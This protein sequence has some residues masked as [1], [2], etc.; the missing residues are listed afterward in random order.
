MKIFNLAARNVFRHTRRSIITAI[1]ISVGLSAMIFMDS[2]MNSVDK[3]AEEN[4]LHYELGNITVFAQGYYREEGRYGLDFIID[5]PENLLNKLSVI[6][7]V[8]AGT[9][10]I[11]FLCQ[12]NNGTDELPIL[13]IG[14]EPQQDEKVFKL[15]QA[16]VKGS[17]L[18]NPDDILIGEALAKDL[19]L[20]IG[21]IAT[22]IAKDRDGTYNAYDF[23]VV[24]LINSGHPAIDRNS[25]II[26]LHRAQELLNLPNA[27]TEISVKTNAKNLAGLKSEI[28][29]QIGNKY[30]LYTWRELYT[31]ILEISGMKRSVQF[32]LALVVVIIAAVG[33]INT[34]LMAVM[35][36]VNEIGMLKAMGFSNSHIVKMFIYEGGIIGFFGSLIGC[37]LGIALS[38]YLKYVGIDLSQQFENIDI[39][40]PIKF[41][42]KGE[43]NYWTV[44]AVLGFGVIISILVTL[45]P[46]RRAIKLNPAEALR[47]I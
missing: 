29:N 1:A 40:Y 5:N 15:K 20:E 10:R 36:R 32:I 46:V 42:L 30:E 26:S 45:Y 33:I 43:I 9:P 8:A 7:N 27:V 6:K 28:L 14:I 37:F 38:L 18:N 31:N 12:L 21:S 39:M 17:Y 3:L 41:I 24:G 25:A 2:M 47:K 22:I 23:I 34:M 16:I 4:I 44:I 35:E 13:G 19:D 11:R